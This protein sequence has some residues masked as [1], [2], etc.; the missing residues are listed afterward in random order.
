MGIGLTAMF[1]LCAGPLLYPPSA[2]AGDFQNSYWW[3]NHLWETLKFNCSEKETANE[4]HVVQVFDFGVLSLI[5]FYVL[6]LPES[7]EHG[8][9]CEITG[10]HNRIFGHHLAVRV[11][12]KLHDYD[13]KRWAFSEY[14]RQS[15][16]TVSLQQG[17]GARIVFSGVNPSSLNLWEG[18]FLE[19]VSSL[20]YRS[21]ASASTA[22]E[23]NQIIINGFVV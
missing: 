17:V 9:A 13:G 7:A 16:R 11:L 12:D 19:G 22:C 10:I 3:S 8:M 18:N 1:Y 20:G 6:T 4:G 21:W 2:R 15:R 5:G 23:R 14:Y